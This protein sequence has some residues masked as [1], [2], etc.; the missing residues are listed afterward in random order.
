MESNDRELIQYLT[1]T[2]PQLKRLYEKHLELEE[3]LVEYSNRVFLTADEEMEAKRLK[4]K[5]LSGVD[6]MMMILHNHR[7]Q[8]C[9]TAATVTV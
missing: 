5:K 8:S 6:Q 3:M 9:S 7:S 4:K 1:K 2:D